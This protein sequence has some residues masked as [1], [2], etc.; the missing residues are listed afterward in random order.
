M[1][2]SIGKMT[3]RLHSTR[4]RYRRPVFTCFL[5]FPFL[6]SDGPPSFVV[7]V[8]AVVNAAFVV[9]IIIDLMFSIPV[10]VGRW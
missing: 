8:V 5:F 6:P 10:Y 1:F 4:N 3:G 9:T 7:V 2:E